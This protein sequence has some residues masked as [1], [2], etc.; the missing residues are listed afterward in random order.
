MLHRQTDRDSSKNGRAERGKRITERD[1][2]KSRER[3]RQTKAWVSDRVSG[4]EE[5]GLGRYVF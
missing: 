1:K 3:G 4:G 5:G 2:K